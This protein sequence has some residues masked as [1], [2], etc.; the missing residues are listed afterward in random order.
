MDIS[1]RHLTTDDFVIGRIAFEFRR[2][3][4]ILIAVVQNLINSR[5]CLSSVKIQIVNDQSVLVARVDYV[6]GD[7]SGN[8]TGNHSDIRR[9]TDDIRRSYLIGLSILKRALIRFNCDVSADFFKPVVDDQF[10]LG[11]A[12][13][14]VIAI[15]GI[16]DIV[17]GDR[18]FYQAVY[19]LASVGVVLGQL[20]EA[21]FP[22]VSLG[23][24]CF[25][26]LSAVIKQMYSDGVRSGAISVV[27]IVPDLVAFYLDEFVNGRL[28]LVVLIVRIVLGSLAG[29]GDAV[30]KIS[31]KIFNLNGVLNSQRDRFTGL[32]SADGSR[33]AVYR[34]SGVVCAYE[35]RIRQ[36]F[37]DHDIGQREVADVLN[38]DFVNCLL[39]YREVALLGEVDERL[40]DFEVR[41]RFVGRIFHLTGRYDGFGVVGIFSLAACSGLVHHAAG[42]NVVLGYHVF[43]LQYDA[44]FAD[45][46]LVDRP[47]VSGLF[48]R[49]YDIRNGEV[50][51][52]EH[53]DLVGNRLAECI[54]FAVCRLAYRLL[55]YEEARRRRIRRILNIVVILRRLG[56]GGILRIVNRICLRNYFV[57]YATLDQIVFRYYVLRAEACACAYCELCNRPAVAGPFVSYNYI[58][59]RYVALVRYSDLVVDGFAKAYGRAFRYIGRLDDFKF[60]VEIIRLV[61][62]LVIILGFNR[63]RILGIRD[64]IALRRYAVHNLSCQDV[65]AG[66]SVGSSVALWFKQPRQAFFNT[67]EFKE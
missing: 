57:K 4:C 59:V 28:F 60:E 21:E 25:S 12:V 24:R 26:D 36:F 42:K 17:T 33:H 55:L 30:L 29:S 22:A 45:F 27:Q 46:E 62:F 18:I 40:G 64:R 9:M 44:H 11:K 20:L 38:D 16:G 47:D 63:I 37:S 54:G 3:V 8:Y 61:L 7:V 49:Y 58:V 23:Y 35:Y 15:L 13:G 67:Q 50:A 32:E 52:I 5:E 31:G 51:V 43:S 34:R 19:D 41:I 53:G 2:R 56:I 6:V 48:I 66:H 14:D 1:R 65:V 10:M 39:A